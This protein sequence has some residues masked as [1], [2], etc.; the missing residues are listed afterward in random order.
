[1]KRNSIARTVCFCGLF[2]ALSI[3]FGKLLQI[4]IGDS[5]RISFENLPILCAAFCFG[6][7]IASLV[8]VVADLVGCLIV[9]FAINPIITLG[10]ALIGFCAGLFFRLFSD[11]RGFFGVMLSVLPAHLIASVLVK[12]LG[13]YLYF[14]T[15]FAV[16]ALRLPIYLITGLLESLILYE[17]SKTP[18]F[19]NGK[20]RA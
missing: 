4:P 15:P 6:P 8:G 5:L 17:L 11:K 19:R 13:L 2:A 20:E 3:V 10:A 16:L 9:G 12:S 14:G 7:W 18:L 1:M